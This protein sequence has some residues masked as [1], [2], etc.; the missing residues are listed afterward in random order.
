M[1]GLI[2]LCGLFV[3]GYNGRLAERDRVQAEIVAM[4]ADVDTSLQKQAELKAELAEV[5]SDA[6]IEDKMRDCWT[7]PSLAISS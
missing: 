6:N 2:V 3:Y 5:G 7:T 1:I 4:R